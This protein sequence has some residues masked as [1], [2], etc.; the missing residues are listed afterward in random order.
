NANDSITESMFI[1]SL[2]T[3]RRRETEKKIKIINDGWY[4]VYREN[5][6]DPKYISVK[7]RKI[8]FTSF[9]EDKIE[10]MNIMNDFSAENRCNTCFIFVLGG[11]EM[12]FTFFKNIEGELLVYDERE[13]KFISLSEVVSLIN[14]GEFDIET[15]L[16]K[17]KKLE[18]QHER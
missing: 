10:L 14:K 16:D 13:E 3:V 11:V 15:W 9:R 6:N 5:P 2:E 17:L 12:R 8:L 7:G 18:K 1:N 4:F